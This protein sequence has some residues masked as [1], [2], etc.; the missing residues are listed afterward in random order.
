[1]YVEVY[2]MRHIPKHTNWTS[3]NINLI[4]WLHT[5]WIFN[6]VSMLYYLLCSFYACMIWVHNTW[7]GTL[8]YTCHYLYL[9]LGFFLHSLGCFL[10]TLNLHV[11]ILKVGLRWTLQLRSRPSSRSKRISRRLALLARF[12]LSAREFLSFVPCIA[13]FYTSWW[14]NTYV[15]LCHSMWLIG[16]R[17]I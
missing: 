9:P 10:T 14:C 17:S 15:I 4:I 16:R 2:G 1:L 8:V 12:S 5:T 6:I 7:P 3:L 13:Y 11:Q